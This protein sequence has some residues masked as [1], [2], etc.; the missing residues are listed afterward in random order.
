MKNV[1]ICLSCADVCKNGVFIKSEK[2][3][4]K[5]WLLTFRKPKAD[6][7]IVIYVCPECYRSFPREYLEAIK[8]KY[9]EKQLEQTSG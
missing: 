8:M 2:E 4:A 6:I 1:T 7:D 5:L 3:I 9:Y